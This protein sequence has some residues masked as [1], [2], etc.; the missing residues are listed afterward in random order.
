M[1]LATANICNY[2]DM[3]KA[4]VIADGK[5]MC[6]KTQ[7]WGM[8]ENN[9][10]EDFPAIIN[11]VPDKW[12]AKH[13]N[14]TNLPIFWDGSLYGVH[15]SDRVKAPFDPVLPKCARPRWQTAVKMYKKER[16]DLP[17]FIVMNV[18]FI[19][20]GYN[21]DKEP[22]RKRQWDIEW[23]VL[24]EWFKVYKKQGFT[25]FLLGDLNHPNPP[26]PV[27]DFKWICGD[28]IDRIGVTTVGSVRWTKEDQGVIEL[29]S[30]HAGRW[31]RVSL[32]PR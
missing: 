18:H 6:E 21:G 28:G 31:V 5:E 30:D 23:D 22:D 20:G 24:V 26:K 25:V 17:D 4:D 14:E 7:V 32:E 15:A 1:K 27:D 12:N 3:P 10:A 29:N 19:A 13:G 8:Q 9:P 2:P 16:A 11:N